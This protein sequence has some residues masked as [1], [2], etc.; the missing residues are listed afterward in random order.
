MGEDSAP[1]SH[2]WAMLAGVWLVYFCFGSTAAAIAEARAIF[3]IRKFF[4]QSR[5]A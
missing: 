4:T 1:H 2:R 5:N 3:W